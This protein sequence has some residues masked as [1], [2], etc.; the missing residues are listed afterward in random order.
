MTGLA[1]LPS[2]AVRHTA[3]GVQLH[4]A[5]AIRARLLATAA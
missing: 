1:M 3:R 2:D 5:A 4:A